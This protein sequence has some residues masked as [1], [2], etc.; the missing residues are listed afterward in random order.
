M[1]PMLNLRCPKCKKKLAELQGDY[2]NN[3]DEKNTDPSKGK[4]LLKCPRC[5]EILELW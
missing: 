1:E 5:K 2:F 4:I 3:F